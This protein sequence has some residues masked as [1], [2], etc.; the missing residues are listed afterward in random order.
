MYFVF[1]VGR[2]EDGGRTYVGR[3]WHE[4]DLLPAKIAPSHGG[5]FVP[6]GG[7]EHS[8]FDYE[9]NGFFKISTT[10]FFGTT[11]KKGV[12]CKLS[13]Y[14]TSPLQ[15]GGPSKSDFQE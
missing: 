13:I 11:N 8:K 5:A 10:E 6:Y 14:R 7:L 1:Q 12:F 4:G 15:V 9:V 3:S 2:D